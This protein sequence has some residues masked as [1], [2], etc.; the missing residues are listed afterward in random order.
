MN[1]WRHTGRPGLRPSE[2][3]HGTWWRARDPGTK[4]PGTLQLGHGE[5][6]ALTAMGGVV[7]DPTNAAPRDD[8]VAVLGETSKGER[9]TLLHLSGVAWDGA[10]TVRE[11][12]TR[13]LTVIR[14]AHLPETD[15]QQFTGAAIDTDLLGR[16]AHGPR[17]VGTAS[18]GLPSGKVVEFPE[19]EPERGRTA[20]APGSTVRLY[21]STYASS[22]PHEGTVGVFPQWVIRSDEPMGL[23]QMFR[24]CILPLLHLVGFASQRRDTL[25]RSVLF[26]GDDEAVE[27]TSTRWPTT[28]TETT[29][30]IWKTDC[31]LDYETMRD[32]FA[33]LLPRWFALHAR[34]LSRLAISILGRSTNPDVVQDRFL[35]RMRALEQWYLEFHGDGV[36]PVSSEDYQHSLGVIRGAVPGD[37][38]EVL[39]PRIAHANRP[40]LQEQLRQLC[41]EAGGPVGEWALWAPGFIKDCVRYRDGLTHGFQKAPP[42][43]DESLWWASDILEAILYQLVLIQLGLD[44][45]EAAEALGRSAFCHYLTNGHENPLNQRAL[46]AAGQPKPD[47]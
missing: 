8:N 9:F 28:V 27:L 13:F 44:Q 2:T 18:R 15:D 30:R 17:V 39:E 16:W 33:D 24:E 12:R 43:D 23:D 35:A 32:R 11:E 14:G 29:R 1:L 3:I 37:V 21:W 46:Q 10:E 45:D 5:A 6:A 26:L 42:F 4:V 31:V 47:T 22:T 38:W 7:T 34:P 19:D 36:R 20:Q 25:M 41:R 40:S